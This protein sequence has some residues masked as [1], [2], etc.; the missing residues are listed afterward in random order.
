[1]ITGVG[2]T[3]SLLKNLFTEIFLN[4]T[5]KV[6]DISD[7]SVLNATAFGVAK[8]G[9]KCI[10]ELAISSSKIFPDTASG[11]NLDVSASLFGVSPRKGET[12]SSTYI[13]VVGDKGTTYTQGV[14]IF[15]NTQ[16]VR[17]GVEKTY[18]IGDSGYGY[19]K[20]RSIQLGEFTNVDAFSINSVAP[21]PIG[22]YS[23]TN[24]YRSTGG[25]DSETDEELRVRIKDNLNILSKGTLE[26]ILQV[27]QSFDSR[28]VGVF[29]NG[30]NEQGKLEVIV[31][32]CDGSELSQDE[33][34]SLTDK[35]SKYFPLDDQTVDRGLI[36]IEIKNVNYIPIGG[37]VGIDFRFETTGEFPIR[38]VINNIQM[39]ITDATNF[40]KFQFG[41]KVSRLD[42]YFAVRNAR[43]VKT[44]PDEF[45]LPKTDIV[46]P[47]G[48]L[49]RVKKLVIRDLNG[50]QLIGSTDIPIYYT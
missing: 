49:P 40:S 31:Y 30:V 33:L 43:G 5:D 26:N 4:K 7:N 38:D 36:G 14:Q 29:N 46:S 13:R 34:S 27:L 50:V 47:L 24:E 25:R 22:H 44:L 10:K 18:T 6:S 23:C 12:G 2:N 39:A 3:I 9:Q 41:G 32:T 21:S 37:D 19:V 15:S 48:N 45:F 8:V 17:F 16:G 11:S 42:L 28:I 20:V 35:S 1:M